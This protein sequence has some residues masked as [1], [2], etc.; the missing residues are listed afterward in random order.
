M[1]KNNVISLDRNGENYYRQGIK[2]RQ[3]N[4]I[5]D[6]LQL[7]KKAYDKNPKNID[8]LTEYAY[9]MTE[10]GFG[11]EAEHLIIET[12]VSD[13]YDMEYFYILSQIN[14]IKQDAN[15]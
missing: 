11:S 9:V 13:D 6:A 10:N 1:N 5:K 7:L 15:K 8:Y 4:N 3:Q 2:K 14:V 12:F